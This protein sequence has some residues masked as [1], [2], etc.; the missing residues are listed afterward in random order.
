MASRLAWA[1]VSAASVTT[2]ASVVCS[3]EVAPL[4]PFSLILNMSVVNVRGKP[5]LDAAGG[6]Q[7][8][9]RTAAEHDGID[10]FHHIGGIE[11]C[12]LARA[13][14]ATADID[15]GDG[16]LVEHD[17]RDAGSEP[18]VIGVADADAGNIGE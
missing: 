13:G 14:R 18:R 6:V 5:G 3:T 15:R 10:A 11:Q 1:L 17:G 9:R 7:S 4:P 8:E 2:T 16:G 12:A